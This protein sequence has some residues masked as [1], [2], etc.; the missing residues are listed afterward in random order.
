MIFLMS[1][2]DAWL[3]RGKSLRDGT[4]DE[5]TGSSP[6]WRKH[7]SDRRSPARSTRRFPRLSADGYSAAPR[8][9]YGG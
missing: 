9:A 6:Y 4:S 8:R 3:V 2:L 5:S 1:G 7:A